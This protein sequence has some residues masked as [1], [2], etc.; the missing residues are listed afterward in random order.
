MTKQFIIAVTGKQGSGK[1]TFCNFL[2]K[3]LNADLYHL[4]IYSHKALQNEE[5]KKI[6]VSKFG[7]EILKNGEIDRKIVGKIV[8]QNEDK[9]KFLNALVYKYM[10]IAIKKDLENSKKIVILDYALLP[11]TEFWIMADYKICI[12]ADMQTRM[13]RLSKRDNV[14]IE[15]LQ[16]RENASL[17]YD[18]NV[19]KLI[20]NNNKNNITKTAYETSKE[21]K[22]RLSK[23]NNN[24][25]LQF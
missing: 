13:E 21:I 16:S 10:L 8:F 5:V 3:E 12:E 20:I 9:L 1:S 7:S 4:D 15:Y 23:K 22:E 19:D 25:N 14:S 18:Y 11:K 17:E 2:A 6:L 24:Y